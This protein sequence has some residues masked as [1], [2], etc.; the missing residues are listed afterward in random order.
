[1]SGNE[2]LLK[3]E[4]IAPEYIEAAE[5]A[6]TQAKP[7]RVTAFVK[8]P[9][10]KWVAAAAAIVVFAVGT[11]LALKPIWND[12]SSEQ[13]AENRANGSGT[14]G[15]SS[16]ERSDGPASSSETLSGDGSSVHT[17]GE[18][19]KDNMPA[20]TYKINGENRSFVYQKSSVVRIEG[21]AGYRV[22]DH[23]A[24]ASG[25]TISTNAESGELVEYGSGN[26]DNIADDLMI[27]ENE[28]IARAKRIL[29]NT[30]IDLEGLEDASAVFRYT[31]DGYYVVLTTMDGSAETSF[32]KEGGLLSLSVIKA[33]D[34][35][36]F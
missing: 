35:S 20:A 6:P 14:P 27:S 15:G 31:D 33:S 17:E 22:L 4:L 13:T 2:L 21:E 10:V 24:D 34:N 32:N 8:K 16:T 11:P 3:M 1:M 23:Y 36:G 26:S 7:S 12:V 19:I 25:A 30:D 18:F 5:K 9:W 29:I 28:A